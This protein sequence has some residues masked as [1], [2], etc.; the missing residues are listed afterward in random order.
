MPK[1]VLH[2]SSCEKFLP[3]FVELINVNFDINKH[4]FHLTVGPTQERLRQFPNVKIEK[5]GIVGRFFHYTA[6]LLKMHKSENII[7]HGL[8]DNNVLLILFIMPW[9]C[10]KSYWVIWGGDLYLYKDSD[11]SAKWRMRE[12]LRQRV[13][14]NFGNLITYIPGDF[15]LAK[16]W[17]ATK[18]TYHEC[19]MYTSN[20]YKEYEEQVKQHK[21]TNILVG[22]SADPSNNHIEVFEKL[23]NFKSQD[24][25]IYV[26]LTYGNPDYAK[27]IIE[28][29]KQRFGDKFEALTEHMPF[30]QYL[31]F[32]AK[33]DIAIFNHNRQQAM[34]NTITLLG[35]GKKV[36]MR[37]NV[38]QWCFFKTHGISVCDIEEFNLNVC[39]RNQFESNKS[40]IKAYFSE[41]NLL[42]QLAGIFSE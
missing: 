1:K 24:I 31:E 40:I 6:A 19:F 42:N 12:F 3:G 33:I 13:I 26:P 29:G 10:K 8:F 34:G 25:K 4:H 28:Q 20:L 9:L 23:E 27:M 41:G 39:E 35:L 7:I 38:T 16:Q 21:G 36:F 18:G 30:N 2:L 22:N 37:S 14:K 15:Q 11:N 17:Y 5:K 32:L